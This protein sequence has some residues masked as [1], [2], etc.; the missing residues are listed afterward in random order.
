MPS[1]EEEVAKVQLTGIL[2][3]RPVNVTSQT[4]GILANK[5]S[6]RSVM[7][8]QS[9]GV[10]FLSL[11][12]VTLVHQINFSMYCVERGLACV[13]RSCEI[14]CHFFCHCTVSWR[15]GP[16]ARGINPFVCKKWLFCV[17]NRNSML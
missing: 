5:W 4:G 1:A 9:S 12:D 14:G 16:E 3:K 10:L 2:C 8:C 13:S 6:R 15:E 11:I 7:V 17:I